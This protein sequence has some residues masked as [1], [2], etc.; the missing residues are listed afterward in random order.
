MY[1]RPSNP[2]GRPAG[3]SSFRPSAN[4]CWIW[5]R[6]C[7]RQKLPRRWVVV[8]VARGGR[9]VGG[10]TFGFAVR[11]IM[12]FP[13][14]AIGAKRLD[15]VGVGGDILQTVE[16]GRKANG[17]VIVPPLGEPVLDVMGGGRGGVGAGRRPEV[18]VVLQLAYD[19]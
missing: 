13:L 4:P 8:Q 12:S 2:G 16:P 3:G 10:P 14:E 7:H 1:C 5:L 6:Q 11:Q 15:Q 19:V 18:R 9:R 17:R